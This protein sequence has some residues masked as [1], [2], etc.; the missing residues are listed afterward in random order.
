MNQLIWN[1]NH[2]KVK[3]Y[4]TIS[5]G[6]LTSFMIVDELRK[7]PQFRKLVLWEIDKICPECNQPLPKDK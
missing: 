7:Y 3:V 6:D 2:T 5:E 1:K 4:S